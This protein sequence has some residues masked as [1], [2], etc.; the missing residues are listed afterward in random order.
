MKATTSFSATR[1]LVAVAVVVAAGA[2]AGILLSGRETEE[3]SIERWRNP[4]MSNRVDDH[5]TQP[6]PDAEKWKSKLT[7]EQYH[8]TREKGTERAFTGKYWNHHGTG[9]Y[10]CVCCGTPLFDSKTKFDSGTGW[11]SFT[12]PIAEKN[13]ETHSDF[14]LSMERTEVL[15]RSCK[16]HLGHVFPDGPRPTGLRYCINSAALDFEEDQPAPKAGGS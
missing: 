4:I 11:P 12:A 14:I 6:D 15:C 13:V 1:V 7:P 8:V 5:K 16:A 2:C 9:L 10:K 3:M